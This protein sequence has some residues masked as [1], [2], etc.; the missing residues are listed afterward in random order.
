MAI[1]LRNAA[2]AAAQSQ[3]S[4]NFTKPRDVCAS[5]RS[6]PAAIALFAASLAGCHTFIGSASPLMGEAAYASAMPDQASAYFGSRLVA[7]VKYSIARRV[8]LG[9]SWFQ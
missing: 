3:S 4:Q 6:G 2:S 8:V 5:G 9:E 1:A 7:R